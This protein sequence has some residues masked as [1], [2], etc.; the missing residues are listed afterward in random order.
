VEK[1]TNPQYQTL[2]RGEDGVDR[3]VTSEECSIQFEVDGPYRAMV[4]PA[5]KVG[6]FA[7]LS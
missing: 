5:S 6:Y 7:I 1:H 2:V 3:Y 4:L